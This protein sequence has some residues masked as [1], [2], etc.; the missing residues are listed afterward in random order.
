MKGGFTEQQAGKYPS[1]LLCIYILKCIKNHHIIPLRDNLG[2][3][4]VAYLFKE[5]LAFKH[6]RLLSYKQQRRSIL[7]T[8]RDIR[9][10]SLA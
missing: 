10:R 5:D 8:M 3:V 6:S 9:A 7:V 1:L 4:L 2:L